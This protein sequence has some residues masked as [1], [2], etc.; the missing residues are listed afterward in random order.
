L[1][2]NASNCREDVTT[3]VLEVDVNA[4]RRRQGVCRDP[5]RGGRLLN[6]MAMFPLRA[7]RKNEIFS[8]GRRP[9]ENNSP[10]GRKFGLAQH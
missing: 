8:F 7:Y 4:V 2:R 6:L 10:W 5:A 9:N 1:T 3:D